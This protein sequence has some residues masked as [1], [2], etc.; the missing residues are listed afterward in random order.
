MTLAELLEGVE[1]V[2]NYADISVA[3]SG[4]VFDSRKVQKGDIFVALSGEQVDGHNF[5]DDAIKNGAVC[6]VA[7]KPVEAPYVVVKDTRKALALMA[8]NFYGNSHKRLE[9]ITVVGTNGKTTTTYILNEILKADGRK[10]AV[11]GTLGARIVEKKIAIDLTT[12]DPMDLHKLFAEAE[13][14]GAQYVIMEASAHALFYRKLEGITATVGVFTNVS[15]DHLDFFGTMKKYSQVKT[16]YFDGANM[17]VGI[18]N[19]DNIYGRKIISSEKVLCLSYGIDSPADIFAVNFKSRGEKTCFFAN[20]LDDLAEI[21]MPLIGKFN[22]YNTLGAIGAARALKVPLPVIGQALAEIKEVEGRFNI[23][24][25]DITV[26]I[27][28]AHTPDGLENLLKAAKSLDGEKV[29]TVFGCGGNRDAAKRPI[30]GIIAGEYS[31]FCVITSDNP[32]MEQPMAIIGQIE[33]GMKQKN[34]NYICIQDR[35][36]AIAYAISF[37]QKGDK[38]VV[39]GKGGENYLDIMGT[40]IPY[41]DKKA[42]MAALERRV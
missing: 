42:V 14:S 36:N 3:V 39:A 1:T 30:M 37:A 15:Q 19:A 4:I 8:A 29:I 20:V 32:R 13:K 11:I 41:S 7:E 2:E 38:V 18:I 12:P 6:V 22:L 9:I 34:K 5:V 31:D 17:K 16:D 10:T 25:T 27:D 33:E 24:K 21:T 26:I 23:I 40:K 28:Y 35:S